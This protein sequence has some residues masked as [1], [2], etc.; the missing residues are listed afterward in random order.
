MWGKEEIKKGEYLTCK[1]V[2]YKKSCAL[3]SYAR[4]EQLKFILGISSSVLLDNGAFKTYNDE[5]KGIKKITN[6]DDHWQKYYFWVFKYYHLIDGFFIPDV[7]NGTEKQNDDL[8]KKL[9]AL[10]RKKAI[11]VWHSIESLDRLSRLCVEFPKVAIG[12]CGKHEK[13]TSKI[14]IERIYEV[15]DWVYVNNNFDV[16][17]HGLRM[18]DGRILGIFPFDSVDSS[19]VAINVPKDKTQM[20]QVQNKISM[21]AIYKSKCESV[22]PPNVKFWI[23]RR[24]IKNRLKERGNSYEI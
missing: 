17:I 24:K 1:E 7:I 5:K 16:K 8:L 18:L 10:I 2:L 12:L 20:P 14:A 3:V 11:P 22:F 21:T 9:P 6:W 23:F 13:T 4:P 19:F 15:F